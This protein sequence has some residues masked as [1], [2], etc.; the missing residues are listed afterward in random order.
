MT[1]IARRKINAVRERGRAL[2]LH[3]TL[4][5]SESITLFLS[6]LLLWFVFRDPTASGEAVRS[7]L[8]LSVGSVIPA[9]FPFLVLSSLLTESGLG[10]RLGARLSR[11]TSTLFGISGS[12]AAALLLGAFCGFPVGARIVSDLYARGALSR[13][14][15][16]R[17][18]ILSNGP[19]FA[20]LFAA[21]GGE[22]FKDRTF[23]LTL[24]FA[25]VAST[26]LFGIVLRLFCGVC[27]HSSP[28]TSACADT[29]PSALFVS[30]IVRAGETA[31]TV[32]AF[33]V[34]FSVLSSAL[35]ALLT[36]LG[37]PSAVPLFLSGLLELSRG[38]KNAAET[39]NGLCGRV[40]CGFFAGWGGL[41]A[42]L[43]VIATAERPLPDRARRKAF[44]FRSYFFCKFIT[45]LLCALFV[46]LVS[47]IS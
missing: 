35:N 31:I 3:P 18:L 16:E 22:F 32:S 12:G 17:L 40:L 25:S 2:R 41:C 11:V 23:G 13:S 14:E 46:W 21:V 30:S 45:G 39:L 28:P 24:Y 37:A 26:L 5:L 36:A 10:E 20:F 7:G 27:E 8:Q 42:H 34:F 29:S 47:T 43:Q 1:G 38:M 33:V 44:S 6:A 4:S 19:S 15:S 9:L